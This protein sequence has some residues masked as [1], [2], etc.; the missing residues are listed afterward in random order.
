M[1]DFLTYVFSLVLFYVWFAPLDLDFNISHVSI[2]CF[3]MNTK[4]SKL[5][6]CF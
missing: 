6:E 3:D 5:Y 1:F 4:H 2:L